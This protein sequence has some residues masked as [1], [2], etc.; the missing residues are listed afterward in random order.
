MGNAAEGTGRTDPFNVVFTHRR[1]ARLFSEGM[2]D[3]FFV[4]VLLAN[5][6]ITVL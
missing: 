1:P 6:P 2:H 3:R 4:I 5:V